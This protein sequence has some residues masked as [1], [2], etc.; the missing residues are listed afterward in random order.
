M[1]LQILVPQYHETERDIAHLLDSI[2]LQRNI[3]FRDIGVI[4]VNDESDVILNPDFLH[5]Y[6]FKVEYIR[7]DEH[8]GVSAARN[9]A[10]KHATA[11]YVMFCDADDCFY[12]CLGLSLIFKQ[13]EEHHPDCIYSSF[14]EEVLNQNTSKYIYD[15]RSHAF[16]FVHGKVYNRK[17]LLDRDIWWDEDLTLHEDGYFNGLALAQVKKDKMVYIDEPFYLW[18]WNGNSVSKSSPTFILDTYNDNLESQDRLI[19]KLLPIN[20]KE[21]VNLVAIQF[22]QTYHLL[23]G[24]FLDYTSDEKLDPQLRDVIESELQSTSDRFARFYEKFKDCYRYVVPSERQRLFESVRGGA[25]VFDNKPTTLES[26]ESWIA[27]FKEERGINYDDSPIE[28]D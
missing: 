25:A 26:Y 10:L 20:M 24:T 13:I 19:S 11:D 12:H 21:A 4:I 27:G 28:G 6:K 5:R 22:Y 1:T 3:D 23:T 7:M 14:I 2:E 9:L 8:G 17:F 16:V 18:C 15:V